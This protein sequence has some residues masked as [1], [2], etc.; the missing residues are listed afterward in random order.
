MRRRRHRD[1]SHRVRDEGRRVD[2]EENDRARD[3]GRSDEERGEHALARL[4]VSNCN[5]ELCGG[6]AKASA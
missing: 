6:S 4:L 1:A 3:N 5:E 2:E